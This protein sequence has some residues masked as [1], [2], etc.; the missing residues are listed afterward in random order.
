MSMRIIMSV[1]SLNKINIMLHEK[2]FLIL[3]AGQ[4]YQKSSLLQGSEAVTH[5]MNGKLL[6]CIS[7]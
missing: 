5:L 3:F 2:L 1:L 4:I 6:Y 7:N